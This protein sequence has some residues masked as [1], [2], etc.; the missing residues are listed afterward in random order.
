MDDCKHY[1]DLIVDS[2]NQCIVL[3]RS[4]AMKTD[5]ELIREIKMPEQADIQLQILA[6]LSSLEIFLNDGEYV[7]SSRLF[8]HNNVTTLQCMLS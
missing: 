1:C 2:D 7:M 3:D 8:T 4:H 6:D 5:G